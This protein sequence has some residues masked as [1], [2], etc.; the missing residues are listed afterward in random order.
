VASA[1]TDDTA[2]D[3]AD[4]A[5]AFIESE[6]PGID[7]MS[8]LLNQR[9][10]PDGTLYDVMDVGWRMT[11]AFV[12]TFVDAAPGAEAARQAIAVTTTTYYSHPDAHK[13]WQTIVLHEIVVKA[14]KILS[15]YAGLGA[16]H[17]LPDPDVPTAIL[18]AAPTAI[19]AGEIV[20]LTW[21]TTDAI[22]VTLEPG[23][24]AVAHTGLTEVEPT[25][26]T[27]Y[28]LTAKG[29]TDTVV[30]TALVTVGGT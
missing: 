12:N 5:L 15:I 2:E 26:T 6:L 24:G 30:D 17:K 11:P 29:W 28:R 23:I 13:D 1:P 21:Q 9:T 22:E 10:K 16:V 18:R 7:A 3:Y 8:V 20:L 19:R 27:T 25:V 4:S 14:S